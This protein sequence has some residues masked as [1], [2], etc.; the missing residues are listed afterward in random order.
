MYGSPENVN[1]QLGEVPDVAEGRWET[2]TCGH[3][4]SLSASE[5]VTYIPRHCQPESSRDIHAPVRCP[6]RRL[7]RPE[8]LPRSARRRP[9]ARRRLRV[10]EGAVTRAALLHL[11]MLE[12]A[13]NG[14]VGGEKVGYGLSALGRMD[15]PEV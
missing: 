1:P 7:Q 4:R 9:G 12:V 13:A 14:L 3:E 15:T 6:V 5:S 2:S 8:R 10:G 11:P